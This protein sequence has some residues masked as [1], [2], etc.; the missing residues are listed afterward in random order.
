MRRSF[1]LLLVFLNCLVNT[2]AQS[3]LP[4]GIHFSTQSQIDSFPI[5]YPDC[6]TIQGSV[7]IQGADIENLDSLI[8]ITVIEDTLAISYCSSLTNVDGLIN[9]TSV[10]GNILQIIQNNSLSNLDGLANLSDCEALV[11]ILWNDALFNVG[12]LANLIKYGNSLNISGNISLNNLSGFE[13]IDSIY[14]TLS[15]QNNPNLNT[16]QHL[17]N[18]E[19]VGGSLTLNGLG[20]LSSL[21]GL[22]S[23][24]K[25]GSLTI[26]A[27]N[28]NSLLPLSNLDTVN[29]YLSINNTLLSDIDPLSQTYLGGSVSLH[30]NEFL[31]N[32]NGFENLNVVYGDFYFS[33][34][35][36][37]VNLEG[38]NAI[39][40]I[41]GSLHIYGSDLL[42]DLSAL[43]SLHYIGGRL[44]VGNLESVV[45]LTGFGSLKS[46]GGSVL[47][48]FI[49]QLVNLN[50]LDSLETI[51]G[52]LNI[53]LCGALETLEGI[54]G[55]RTLASNLYIS[56]N[57]SLTQLFGL[58]SLNY[59]GGDI[60]LHDN[61]LLNNL[62][63]IEFCDFSNVSSLEIIDNPSLS[64]CRIQSI[65]TFIEEQGNQ[66]VIENNLIG[67]NSEEEVELA[68]SLGPCL[69][70]SLV[71][72]TQAEVDSYSMDYPFCTSINGDLIIEGEDI[73]NVDSLYII[74]SVEGGVFIGDSIG[75]P[76]LSNLEGLSHISHI[77]GELQLKNNLILSNLSGLE[78]ISSVS[79]DSLTIIS[80][81]E[82]TYCDLLNICAFI[83]DSI[84][85][86][87]VSGNAPGCASIEE[88]ELE[89]ETSPCLEG[90]IV[91]VTQGEID[92]FPINYPDCDMILGDVEFD[93][94]EFE[95]LNGLSS[96]REIQGS[97]LVSYLGV[98]FNN[99]SGLGSLEIVEG[100]LVINGNIALDSLI[101][102][103]SL[104]SI[105]GDLKIE[106][107]FYGNTTLVSLEGLSN[108]TSIGGELILIMNNGLD[109]LNGLDGLTSIGGLR[110][111]EN[112]NLSTVSALSNLVEIGGDAR[113]EWNSSLESLNGFQ[114]LQYIEGNFRVSNLGSTDLADLIN[115]TY[116]GGNI[117][118]QHNDNLVN[119]DGLN[120]LS[121][122]N[123][124]LT[125]NSNSSLLNIDALSSID[126]IKGDLIIASNGSLLN[127]D[128]LFG[129]TFV[130]GDLTLSGGINI[131]SL[132]G[133]N[134]IEEIGGDLSVK[135]LSI[136]DF[137]DLNSFT[138]LHGGLSVENCN[139]LIDLKGL[140]GI[141]NLGY[142]LRIVRNDSLQ[143]LNGLENLIEIE[144]NLII[145]GNYNYSNA[146]LY[147][148]DSL[149]NLIE[150]DGDIKI[151][152]NHVLESL[153][154]LE[155]IN[156]NSINS[157]YIID[158]ELLSEC[159]FESFCNYILS[160][161]SDVHIYGNQTGCNS[162][163][164]VY[165]NCITAPCLQEDITFSS[166]QEIDDFIINNP[167]CNYI[168]GDVIIS[169]D[170]IENLDGLE[171]I[172]IIR[173]G[174]WITDN[175]NLESLNGLHNLFHVDGV[176]NIGYNEALED[177]NSLISLDSVGGDLKLI[178]NSLLSQIEGL[179]NV[180]SIGGDLKI[181]T[182]ELLSDLEGLNNIVAS[183]IQN[184]FIVSNSSLSNCAVQS[185]CDYLSTPNGS[186]V[187]NNNLENCNSLEEI[188]SLCIPLSIAEQNNFESITIYPN[189]AN[190]IL[191]IFST[192]GVKIEEV[193]MYNQIG[194]EVL[195]ESSNSSIDV[196]SLTPGLYIIEIKLDGEKRKSKIVIE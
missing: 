24:E 79:M 194:Q 167:L 98:G 183:S 11:L 140:E 111:W 113:I 125:I 122:L 175:P 21:N 114:N 190:D 155:N 145:G 56:Y 2:T 173:G 147:S 178:N 156:P 50:G 3:C 120:G 181:Y 90:G 52:E 83:S 134:N 160:T 99:F 151:Q 171:T 116:I 87:V 174:L 170:D 28:I 69:D 186:T 76:L 97:L 104:H 37:I 149:S 102:L 53:S 112:E 42:A 4:E 68:C 43:S 13:V 66:T 77:S 67:C 127:F 121:R 101:G 88:I 177:L 39:D 166:Q 8:Y 95:N 92:S 165:Y 135:G 144:G 192:N 14:G 51:G 35:A 81:P 48:G 32:I 138:N 133:L 9:L 129:L 152:Q 132:S 16:I 182:N 154:G 187:I 118:L 179:S 27:L 40:S 46:V 189:P 148:L 5:N 193:Q 191:Y 15:I 7:Y 59:I 49:N 146:M 100:D 117:N 124:G 61:L 31:A 130:E 71:L 150:I 72:S 142:D 38:L 143:S 64:N 185:I 136:N 110:I 1:L 84:G 30:S 128:G 74:H 105:G 195:R 141:S 36:A 29:E 55:L 70:T 161:N 41:I 107:E 54:N 162:E 91:F 188:E 23:L 34:N 18:L 93:G 115:L 58:D 164:E 73:I 163:G 103:E 89:C 22:E 78:N 60:E 184:L 25:V 10:G 109:N 169:G 94:W 45:D 44:S 62:D 57:N 176:L 12:G 96:I 158:N 82:L 63:A 80:N 33:N 26:S 123:G 180:Q 153:V 86:V 20:N 65:C 137:I 131:T 75:N 47:I 119:L 196:S 157:L 108:L 139:S 168:E 159:S 17:G 126:S 172:Q 6:S 85:P 19:Y 106:G